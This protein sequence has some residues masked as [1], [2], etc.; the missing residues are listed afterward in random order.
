MGLKKTLRYPHE[1]LQKAE[2]PSRQGRV[3]RVSPILYLV[4]GY[5]C[6]PT[7]PQGYIVEKLDSGI[8]VCQCN[9]FKK[10][11]VSICSHIVA[12]MRSEQLQKARLEKAAESAGL[13]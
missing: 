5:H 3:T 6:A 11:H 2:R 8:W 9:G 10:R 1:L 13:G 4:R 7:Y 12:A